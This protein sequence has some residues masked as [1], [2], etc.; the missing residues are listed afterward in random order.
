[1]AEE[2]RLDKKFKANTMLANAGV[3]QSRLSRVL[4]GKKTIPDF[5]PSLPP[6][7]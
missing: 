1:L 6:M 7:V 2:P 3:G 5:H 4:L